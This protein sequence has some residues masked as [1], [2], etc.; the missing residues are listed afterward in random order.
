MFVGTKINDYSPNL[1]RDNWYITNVES[2]AR[3][4]VFTLGKSSQT[5]G[6]WNHGIQVSFLC[7]FVLI[8]QLI[9]FAV[10]ECHYETRATI[11]SNSNCIPVIESPT[12]R[13]FG[14]TEIS[15]GLKKSTK[16]L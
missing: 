6:Y 3:Q 4:A 10:A 1:S 12:K 11:C 14:E 9:I 7:W 16:M 13:V 15:I 8:D 5:T 2:Y